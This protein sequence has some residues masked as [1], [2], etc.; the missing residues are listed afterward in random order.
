MRAIKK[1]TMKGQFFLIGAFLILLLFYIGISTFFAP[2]YSQKG[3]KG[4]MANFFS[5]VRD[6][7]PAALNLGLNSTGGAQALVN[8]TGIVVN[9]SKSRGAT[10]ATLW[11][12]TQ[13]S[14]DNLNVTIGNYMGTALNVTLNVSDSLSTLEIG[15]GETASVV[16]ASPLSELAFRASFNTTE[17]NLLLEKYKT[18][19]YVFLDMR[20]GSDKITGE[21]VA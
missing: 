10:L 14:S 15:D 21:T 9:A 13:N 20:K 8:F 7:Y 5:N 19:L 18:N 6:E 17:K 16:F 1:K 3:I 2:A 12:L 11:I 4:E